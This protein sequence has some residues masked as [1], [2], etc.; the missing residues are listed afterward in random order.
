MTV[1]L[2]RQ[3]DMNWDWDPLLSTALV[4]TFVSS[5][6]DRAAPVSSTGHPCFQWEPRLSFSSILLFPC[7]MSRR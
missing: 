2:T 1:R 6:T 7:L 3:F 4:S 5:S